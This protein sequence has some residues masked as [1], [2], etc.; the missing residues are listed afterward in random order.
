MSV[1]RGEIKVKS[2]EGN[3]NEFIIQLPTTSNI[4]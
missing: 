3:G 4:P 1:K 2:K